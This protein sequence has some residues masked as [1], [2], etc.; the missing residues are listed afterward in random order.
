MNLFLE[1]DEE[2]AKQTAEELKEL[3]D[4][5]KTMTENGVKE[6]LGQAFEY[7]AKGDKV[8][9]LYL[10][11]CHESIAGIIAGRIKDRL[12]HPAFVLTDA[13]EGIKGSGRSIEGY[14]MFEEMMKV[15][16]VFT[17]FG[18]HANGSRM[19]FGKRKITGIPQKDQ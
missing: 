3:N 7:K 14:S 8:L 4:L 5:R 17:K 6:A 10:P 13:K 19:F 15:K 1:E 12:N 11:E 2:K 18:G 9:V 16:E